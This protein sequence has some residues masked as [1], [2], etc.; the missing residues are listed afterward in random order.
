MQD[1]PPDGTGDFHH[2]VVAEKFRE[3]PPYGRWG[4]LV[5]RAQIAEQHGRAGGLTMRKGGFFGERGGK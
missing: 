5:G 4:R 2:P 3:V 1:E